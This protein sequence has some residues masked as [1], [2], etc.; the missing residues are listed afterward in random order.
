[1]S[2]QCLSSSGGGHA[3]TPPRDRR[4]GRPLPNQLASPT[5]AAPPA[6]SHLWRPSFTPGRIIGHYPSFP[7]AIPVWRVRSDALLPRLPLSPVPPQQAASAP[8]PAR[9]ACL[10]HAANV[11]SEPGSNPSIV[12]SH[13]AS[14]P[15]AERDANKS[16]PDAGGTKAARHNIRCLRPVTPKPPGEPDDQRPRSRH[17]RGHRNPHQ[18]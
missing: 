17:S 1:M 18:A 7:M 11:R 14:H 9:L 3:L 8:D 13:P 16:S 12:L 15:K 4:L 5:S 10:I 2:G 6:D